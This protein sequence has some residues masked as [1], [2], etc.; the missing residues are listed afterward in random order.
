M[1]TPIECCLK[2][3][4]NKKKLYNIFGVK[5]EARNLDYDFSVNYDYKYFYKCKE[6]IIGK[7]NLINEFLSTEK[8]V[9]QLLDAIPEDADKKKYRPIINHKKDADWLKKAQRKFHKIIAKGLGKIEYLH[10]TTKKTSYATNGRAHLGNNNRYLFCLDISSFFTGIDSNRVFKTVKNYLKLD[11][12]VAYYYSKL[13]TAPLEKNSS[14]LFLAQGLPSSPILAFLCYKTLFDYINEFSAINSITFTLYVDDMTFSSEQEIP[15]EFI[16]KIIGLLKS[17]RYDNKLKINNKKTHYNKPSTRKII[18]G[19]YINNG[20]ASI[21]GK[22]HFELFV[23]YNKLIN[24][25]HE[26]LDT[27]E[28]Y[29]DF[30]N[31]FLKFSGNLIHLFQ[32]E[33]GSFE[34]TISNRAHSKMLLFYRELSKYVKPGIN[35]I[36]SRKKYSEENVDKESLAGIDSQWKNLLKHQNRIKVEF[37]KL[38]RDLVQ[39]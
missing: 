8:N 31:L 6:K 9:V 19:V 38:K 39:G 36:D 15:Q 32:V 2:S 27:I 12:D 5:K 14:E 30:Y 34:I 13:L 4:N 28:K 7:R 18:T 22:K 25:I 24:M 33:Y 23:L 3:L 21:S 17:N 29:F 1:I 20:V 16:N 26:E 11:S 37:H 10:S 35:K